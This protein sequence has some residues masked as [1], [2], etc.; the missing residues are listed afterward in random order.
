MLQEL[1]AN[2]DGKIAFL[3]I[4]I[5][6]AHAQDEWPISSGRYV[7]NKQPV[8]IN[9]HRTLSD[10]IDACNSFIKM[11]QLKEDEFHMALDGIENQFE[12]FYGAWPLRWYGVRNGI[13]EFKPNVVDC[14]Y[15]ILELM[16]WLQKAS[17]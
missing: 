11:F 4:Y 15:E 12:R 14:S 17:S 6:E 16:I 7:P 3:F 5:L 2:Y 9:Q 1:R 8:C 10:R 13:L